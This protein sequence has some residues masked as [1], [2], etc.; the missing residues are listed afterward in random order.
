MVVGLKR[1]NFKEDW[2]EKLF[3]LL[4]AKLVVKSRSSANADDK[5][6]RSTTR[7]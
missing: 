1:M 3:S 2:T 7:R 6:E 4:E 5:Q